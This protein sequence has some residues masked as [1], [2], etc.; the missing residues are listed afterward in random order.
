[1]LPP[2]SRTTSGRFVHDAE[3][4]DIT[5]RWGKHLAMAERGR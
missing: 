1:M 2:A 5:L 4:E 3:P